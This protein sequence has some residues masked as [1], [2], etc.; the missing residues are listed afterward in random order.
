[1]HVRLALVVLISCVYV[2]SGVAQESRQ[3]TKKKETPDWL[4]YC[5]ERSDKYKIFASAAQNRPFKKKPEALMLHTQPIRGDQV[6]AIYLWIDEAGRS[7]AVGTVI[8]HPEKHKEQNTYFLVEECHSLYDRSI[9]GDL[10]DLQWNCRG[11]GLEW[12]VLKGADEPQRGKPRLK[13]MAR[14]LAGMFTAEGIDRD[15]GG[16]VRPLRF[17]PN[18][19]HEYYAKDDADE[20][21]ARYLF[22]GCLATDP[23]VF[24]CLEARRTPDGNRWFYSLA[25]FSDMLITVKYDDEEVWSSKFNGHIGAKTLEGVSLSAKD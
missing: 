12:K 10:V 17:Q 1:M 20:S 6:G 23:E 22:A 3:N 9:R 15:T 24:L 18:P 7:A 16:T 21:L 25:Q 8:L 13:V 2:A 11:P 4:R 5:N 14:R 19:V